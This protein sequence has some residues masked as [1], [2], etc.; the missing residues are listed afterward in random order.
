MLKKLIIVV[1]FATLTNLKQFVCKKILSLMTVGI[2]KMHFK[3][4]IVKDRSSLQLLFCQFGQRKTKNTF[5]YNK[6]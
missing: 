2:Y 3:Q 6:N 4:I 5:I 1:L